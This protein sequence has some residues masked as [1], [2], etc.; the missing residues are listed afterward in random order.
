MLVPQVCFKFNLFFL[1]NEIFSKNNAIDTRHSSVFSNPLR[2]D[3]D[4]DLLADAAAAEN[5]APA[6][7]VLFLLRHFNSTQPRTNHHTHHRRCSCQHSYTAASSLLPHTPSYG[8]INQPASFGSG[9][10]PYSTTP[11]AHTP[12]VH[13]PLQTVIVLLLKLLLLFFFSKKKF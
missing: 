2:Y 11:F 1:K 7:F 13:K 4:N 6:R 5:L 12:P 9:F 3:S 10:S 8:S